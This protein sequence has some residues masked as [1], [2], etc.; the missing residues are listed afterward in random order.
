MF[1]HPAVAEYEFIWRLDSDSFLLERP[2]ADPFVQ[3]RDANASYAWIHAFRD[4]AVF[5]TGLL[6]ETQR[7]L[8]AHDIDEARVH[9][10]VPGAKRW[11]ESPM[12]FATNCFLAR[13][14]WFVSEPYTSFFR[15][16]DDSGGFYIHRWGDA[17]VHMLAAA[18]L[19][20]KSAVLQLNSLAYW[21]QGTVILPPKFA[22]AA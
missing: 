13:R 12:C 3:M 8:N 11:W 1:S 15:A 19:L 7:F 18:A 17:C 22:D 4:E 20:D 14:A 5:T 9:T 16:L 10:W 2:A 6:E 21:H